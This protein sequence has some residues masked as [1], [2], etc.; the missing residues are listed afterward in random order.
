[1]TSHAE[2]QATNSQT[3]ATVSRPTLT[4]VAD[5]Y[6]PDP[7]LISMARWHFNQ[8]LGW[9]GSDELAAEHVAKSFR[10]V[11]WLVENPFNPDSRLKFAAKAFE[12]MK[13]A[14]E[15]IYGTGNLPQKIYSWAKALGLFEPLK[16]MP[17]QVDPVESAKKRAEAEGK[18]ILRD[19]KRRAERAAMKGPSGGAS[20][21]KSAK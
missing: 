1:M 21:K 15:M 18:R 8:A 9:A 2:N 17:K 14:Y 19:A 20:G 4:V 7:T 13:A 5:I 16:V 3:Q 11:L 10:Q 12:E 6:N